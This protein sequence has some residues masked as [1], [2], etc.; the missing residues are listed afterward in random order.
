[1]TATRRV[2][3]MGDAAPSFHPDLDPSPGLRRRLTEQLAHTRAE[4]HGRREA[5]APGGERP[6]FG[7]RAGDYVAQVVDDRTNNQLADSLAATAVALER[8]IA[9]LDEGRYGRC[10]V[11]GAEI[12][13]ERLEAVPWAARCVR[14]S[15]RSPAPTP[16]APPVRG[17]S[18][19]AP[20][21][22]ARRPGAA[23]TPVPPVPPVPA[24]PAVPV[25][26]QGTPA[27]VPAAVELVLADVDGTL[28]T[29]DKML[30]ERAVEAVTSSATA[31]ILFAITSGARPGACRCW[32]SRSSSPPRSPP[33][34]AAC[35]WTRTCR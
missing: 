8:A 5:A 6:G 22:A 19:G 3:T 9:L 11:C 14:A 7:K 26:E 27:P 13:A 16:R 32:S 28:V 15:R 30:T 10:E 29:Q 18:P 2:G 33:S 34:T 4:M 35:W 25:A 1:M 20:G 17:G 21:A 23:G 24:V 12:G 31:G